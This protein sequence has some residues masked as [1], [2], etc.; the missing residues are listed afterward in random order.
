MPSGEATH[1]NFKVFSLTRSVLE[2]TIYHTEGEQAKLYTTDAATSD[3]THDLQHANHYTTDAA[4]ND[5]T[6][7]LH[8]ASHAPPMR[9]QMI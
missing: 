2:P 1:T 3:L 8:H 5:L 4:T 9:L 7:D 6:H